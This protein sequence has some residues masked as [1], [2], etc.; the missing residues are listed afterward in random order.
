MIVDFQAQTAGFD[1]HE[2]SWSFC[3][4]QESYE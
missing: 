3:P 2:F 4:P 1:I